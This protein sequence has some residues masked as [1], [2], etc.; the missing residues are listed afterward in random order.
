MATAN[1]GGGEPSWARADFV[2]LDGAKL[3]YAYTYLLEVQAVFKYG[4][5]T[6]DKHLEKQAA[7]LCRRTYRPRSDVEDAHRAGLSKIWEVHSTFQPERKR[8]WISWAKVIHRNAVVDWLRDKD[9]RLVRPLSPQDEESYEPPSGF[10]ESSTDRGRFEDLTSA[11]MATHDYTCRRAAVVL[12]LGLDGRSLQEIRIALVLLCHL[13]RY[14]LWDAH[15]FTRQQLLD[16]L[17]S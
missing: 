2:G 4:V 16:R 11:M 15:V 9:N 7:R 17:Q 5:S 12:R 8:K 10:V 3:Q 1:G 6:Y 14:P 13:G